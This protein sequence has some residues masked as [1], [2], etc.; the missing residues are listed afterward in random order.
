MK[1]SILPIMMAFALSFSTAQSEVKKAATRLQIPL[2]VTQLLKLD[3]QQGQGAV[4]EKGKVVTVHYTGWLHE[5]LKKAQNFKGKKFDS[6]KDRNTTFK[7]TL[8]S[9]QVIRG[10]DQGFAGMKVGGKRTLVIPSYMGYGSRGAG[11]VIPPDANLI[12]DVE[13]I[14]VK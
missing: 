8:G 11:G 5:P 9:G 1:N 12:F 14:D 13:L 6:S 3:T 4:A 10:W 7:F 2:K